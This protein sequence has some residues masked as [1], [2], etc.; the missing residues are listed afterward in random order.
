MHRECPVCHRQSTV[1][2]P[3]CPAC[4]APMGAVP[5]ERQ[6]ARGEARRESAAR[7]GPAP[8]PMKW[9]TFLKCVSI[10]LSFVLAAVSLVQQIRE[11]S[12]FDPANY[13]P[14]AVE[15]VRLS[16]QVGIGV[17]AALLAVIALIEIA[18]VRMRW[19]GVGLLLGNYAF[20]ALYGGW[21]LI[22]FR[23]LIAAV[24]VN[25]TG[26]YAS[27]AQMLLLF[28]LNFIYYR[29]RRA[30]FQPRKINSPES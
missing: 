6:P 25:L 11:L 19:W 26:V 23:P 1:D 4:G 17:N 28:V 20:Q 18:L 22:L 9:H 21:Q 3:Y 27:L 2:A 13:Y 29:K 7:K 24:P 15:A 8:L 16:L 12:A 10:P 14:Q 30:L 5:G